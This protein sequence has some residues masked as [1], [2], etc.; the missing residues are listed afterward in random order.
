PLALRGEQQAGHAKQRLATVPCA[1]DV[2]EGDLELACASRPEGLGRH[3]QEGMAEHY[4]IQVVLKLDP[5]FPP[6]HP[7]A[8]RIHEIPHDGGDLLMQIVLSAAEG[9][10]FNANRRGIGLFG[11]AKRQMRGGLGTLFF[12]G[13]VPEKQS[14]E[15]GS[16]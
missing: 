4:L 9:Y 5:E 16:E 7:P 13:A 10:A 11:C 1:R 8:P 15:R 14:D 2:L 12:T 6:P 3:A